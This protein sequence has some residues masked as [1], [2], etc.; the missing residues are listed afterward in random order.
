MIF[1]CCIFILSKKKKKKKKKKVVGKHVGE[2]MAKEG[3]QRSIDHKQ[4]RIA[5]QKMRLINDLFG[6]RR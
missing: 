1:F 5:V 6:G 4:S 2:S 3:T